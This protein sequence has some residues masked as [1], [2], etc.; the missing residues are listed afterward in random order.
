MC[1]DDLGP[2]HAQFSYRSPEI[3]PQH[4]HLLWAEVMPAGQETVETVGT[5]ATNSVCS[6]RLSSCASHD[7]VSLTRAASSSANAL[8]KEHRSC[9]SRTRSFASSTGSRCSSVDGDV[10]DMSK[11]ELSASKLQLSQ[12][13]PNTSLNRH[14]RKYSSYLEYQR[15]QRSRRSSS[16]AITPSKKSS[17]DTRG[18]SPQRTGVEYKCFLDS[19]LRSVVATKQQQQ[20]RLCDDST[21]Q[22]ISAVENI[23]TPASDDVT[24]VDAVEDFGM[25]PIE[26]LFDQ[27]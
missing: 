9:L 5:I 22:P 15:E 6:S 11:P 4:L 14:K 27:T 12:L 24:R 17:A 23:G 2:A 10:G 19:K 1:C 8:T 7:A 26:A 13:C 16:A 18:R 20:Q 25:H 3:P 21:N